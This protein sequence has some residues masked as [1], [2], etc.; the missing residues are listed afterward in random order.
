M[1]RPDPNRLSPAALRAF[2]TDGCDGWG[3]HGSSTMHTRYA[4]PVEPRS[5]ARCPCCKKRGMR[6]GFANGVCLTSPMCE[7]AS[8]RWVKTGVPASRQGHA[9]SRQTDAEPIG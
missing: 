9:A 2:M 8:A 3:T 4:E 5:R 1:M 6:R 7:M